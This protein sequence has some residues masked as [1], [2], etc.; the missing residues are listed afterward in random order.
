MQTAKAAARV[1]RRKLLQIM[2]AKD[3]DELVRTSKLLS[4]F[5]AHRGMTLSIGNV[6]LKSRF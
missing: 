4:F 5:R 6:A 1:A 2:A 3:F